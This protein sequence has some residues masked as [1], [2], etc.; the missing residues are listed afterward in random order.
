MKKNFVKSAYYQNKEWGSGRWGDRS[1]TYMYYMYYIYTH[2]YIMYVL[3]ICITFINVICT[4]ILLQ[5]NIEH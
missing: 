5:M 1:N 2:T 4:D 3:H